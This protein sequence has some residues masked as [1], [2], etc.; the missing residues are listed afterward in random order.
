MP[1]LTLL[2]RKRLQ[3][4]PSTGFV[5]PLALSASAVLLLGSASIHT[6]ALQGPLH[7]H[8]TVRRQEAADQ[9]RSAAHAFVAAAHGVDACLL[10]FSSDQWNVLAG[11]C[12]NAE[13][14]RLRHGQL[15]LQ[16]WKLL[17]WHPQFDR[18]QLDLRLGDGRAAR[19]HVRLDPDG[20]AVLAVGQPQLLGRLAERGAS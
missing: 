3:H 6:L 8:A 15:E 19:F 5:L 4:Q 13:P 1:L 10:G 7:H 14:D 11:E 12:P 16:A 20:P 2:Y 9:L 18:A 17:A